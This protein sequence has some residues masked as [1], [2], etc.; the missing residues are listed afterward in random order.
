MKKI[1][2]FLALFIFSTHSYGF[3]IRVKHYKFAVE[4]GV[5]VKGN[6]AGDMI[7]SHLNGVAAGVFMSTFVVYS[8]RGQKKLYC[9]PEGLRLT[10]QNYLDILDEGIWEPRRIPYMQPT[11]DESFED[12]DI[13]QIF[14]L[15]L[16]AKFPCT[17]N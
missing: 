11:S 5:V 10:D 6:P 17:D 4:Q 3:S 15:L 8:Y 13:G 16:M 14:A 2:V 1:I 12:W 7:I 9:P